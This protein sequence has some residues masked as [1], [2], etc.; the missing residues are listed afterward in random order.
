[1]TRDHTNIGEWGS[2]PARLAYVTDG[3]SN[4]ILVYESA[5]RGT[6]H[7]IHSERSELPQEW[8][9]SPKFAWAQAYDL[10][11]LSIPDADLITGPPINR[12]N[13]AE[14]FSQHPGG[15]NTLFG[16]A[17]VYFLAETIDLAVLQGLASR[18]GGEAVSP[19]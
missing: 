14:L 15:V 11:L 9:M 17:R 1:M 10:F 19:P 13:G 12:S 7:E 6:F 8:V 18:E 2:W 3:L 5:G 16:D 4:T